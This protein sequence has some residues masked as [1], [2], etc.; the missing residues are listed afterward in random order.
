MFQFSNILGSAG[1]LKEWQ[2][3]FEGKSIKSEI[4]RVEEPDGEGKKTIG[5][6]LYREGEEANCPFH[7]PPL[8]E[9]KCRECG[10]D[11]PYGR[12]YFCGDNCMEKHRLKKHF[13]I[14]GQS[15]GKSYL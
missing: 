11:N 5:Y 1:E 3:W 12:L 9:E 10:E 8:P 6:A 4:R 15:W 13:E 2:S 7:A 14:T